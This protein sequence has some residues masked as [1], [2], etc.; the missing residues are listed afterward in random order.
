[1]P[2]RVESAEWVNCSITV[3]DDLFR[4]L[5]LG[6]HATDTFPLGF[7]DGKI[8]S[9]RVSS[10]DPPEYDRALDWVYNERS[11]LIDEPCREAGRPRRAFVPW[12]RACASSRLFGVTTKQK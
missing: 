8:V 4:A 6:S 3:K 2:C 1:M 11:E 9:A 12:C 10:N 5:G 7:S